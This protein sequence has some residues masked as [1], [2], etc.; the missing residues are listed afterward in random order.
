MS[1]KPSIHLFIPQLLQP[2]NLWQKDFLFEA[3]APQL[4]Q[5]L[6]DFAQQTDTGCTSLD[7][8]LL[9]SVGIRLQSGNHPVA[10]FRS[11][12][13]EQFSSKKFGA[14]LCADP[15]HLEVGMNDITLTQTIDDLR[16]S[17]SQECIDDLNSH[18]KQDNIEFIRG[19]NQHWYI[20]LL[21]EET[22]E[23]TSLDDVLRKNI[24]K[25]LP[26]SNSRNWQV[27]QNESQ[28]IL[29][30]CAV[31]QQREMQGLATV[32]SLWFWGGGKPKF[33]EQ[34]EN[35][36]AKRT[37][38]QVYFN[39]SDYSN[40]SARMI[41]KAID[42]DFQKLPID[43]DEYLK[44]M[45]NKPAKSLMII[46]SL[47]LPAIHDDLDLYQQA[48]SKLDEDIIKPLKEA[49]Q[50][51]KIDLVIDSCNGK[52]MCPLKVPVWKFWKHKPASL[53]EIAR[54]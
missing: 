17:E 36:K 52:V 31:N 7:A 34:G 29:H 6:G 42:C 22:V 40:T 5:L 23:T 18:F 44:E 51:G 14:L 37:I 4:S 47:F 28:M 49:W 2:L 27:I 33:Q 35:I 30:A 19:S 3:E 12:I 46:D 8:S 16:D 20:A 50:A 43:S 54:L 9:H 11:Q 13:D 48:L 45:V 41:A 32:N 15:I 21:E 39:D 38:N 26:R 24:A 53:V 1:M 10:H 25:F